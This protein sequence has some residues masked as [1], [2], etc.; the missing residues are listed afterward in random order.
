MFKKLSALIMAMVLSLSCI[1]IGFA[2]E[3]LKDKVVVEFSPEK[4]VVGQEVGIT[5]GSIPQN[6]MYDNATYYFWEYEYDAE[7]GELK[8]KN[9]EREEIRT[10]GENSVKWTPKKAGNYQVRIYIQPSPQDVPEGK[11]PKEYRITVKRDYTV[12]EKP[13]VTEQNYSVEIN[14]ESNIVIPKSGNKNIQFEAIVKNED[15]KVSEEVIWELKGVNDSSVKLSNEGTLTVSDT[16]K[17]GQVDIIVYLKENSNVKTKKTVTL[18]EEKEEEN[19]RV[20]GVKF[21]V[22]NQ[23]IS[24]GD[25]VRLSATVSPSNSS[26]KSLVWKSDNTSV[27][28]VDSNGRVTGVSSGTAN[29]TVETVDGKFTAT[30]QIRVKSSQLEEEFLPSIN[31][32]Y[33]LPDFYIIVN[34]TM[35]DL[36]YFKSNPEVLVE[37]LNK[38]ESYKI[39]ISTSLT[40]IIGSSEMISNVDKIIDASHPGGKNISIARVGVEYKKVFG[41]VGSYK[42]DVRNAMRD[43][44]YF[45]IGNNFSPEYRIGQRAVTNSVDSSIPIYFYD[46]KGIVI[47]MSEINKQFKTQSIVVKRI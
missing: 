20:T 36:D 37:E 21:D 19:I 35:I 38:Q 12:D 42:V 44:R 22:S 3:S 2:E 10:W 31:I 46:E 28:R 41:E 26:N 16:A 15:K 1:S 18:K 4:Q 24:I 6:S 45:S 17:S 34:K 5:V 40:D 29:I 8:E 13:P 14:G 25:D 9:N 27:A 47:G 39:Y 32:E 30:S 33:K 23:T 7:S 11:D 43:A